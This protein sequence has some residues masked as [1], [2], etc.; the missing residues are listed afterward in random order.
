MPGNATKNNAGAFQALP[1]FLFFVQLN[2]IV[3]C[4]SAAGA[5]FSVIS[6]RRGGGGL[7]LYL[8][9]F[10]QISHFHLLLYLPYAIL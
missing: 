5:Q 6:G 4:F 1:A 3:F 8:F 2:L 7:S 9:I 10:L